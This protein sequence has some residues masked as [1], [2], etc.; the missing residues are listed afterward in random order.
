MDRSLLSRTRPCDR[1][2]PAVPQTPRILRSPRLCVCAPQTTNS[3]AATNSQHEV[4][5]D[6][7]DHGVL[8]AH[9]VA[10]HGSTVRVVEPSAPIS[11]KYVGTRDL[12]SESCLSLASASP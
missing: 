2:A 1:V 9:A 11:W 12:T 4:A 3:E 7:E 10:T 6:V 5:M 8:D